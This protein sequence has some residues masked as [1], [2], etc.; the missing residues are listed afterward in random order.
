MF[1]VDSY[2][3]K[4]LT[5]I[6][7]KN[8][9]SAIISR[10]LRRLNRLSSVRLRWQQNIQYSNKTSNINVDQPKI[11]KVQNIRNFIIIFKVIEGIVQY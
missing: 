5:G 11:A 4:W 2:G 7:N 3:N 9:I 1:S 10:D 8:N 6:L